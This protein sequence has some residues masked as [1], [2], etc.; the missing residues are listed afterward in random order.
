MM[1]EEARARRVRKEEKDPPLPD[2]YL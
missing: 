1:R 2:I